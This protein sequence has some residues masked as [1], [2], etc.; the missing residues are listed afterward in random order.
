MKAFVL[1]AVFEGGPPRWLPS[2]QRSQRASAPAQGSDRAVF[3]APSGLLSR[4]GTSGQ[5][6]PPAVL[7][8]MERFFGA[9]FS[10]VRIHVGR[11]APS[12]G[13]LAFTAGTD[14]FFAPGRY[15][16]HAPTG[17][18]LLGHELTHVLQQRAGRVASPPGVGAAVV[19]DEALE[20]E[21]DRMGALAAAVQPRLVERAAAPGPGAAPAGGARRG[22][23][24]IVGAY[25]HQASGAPL[26]EQLSGH[27]FV[28]IEG[29][30]GRKAFGFSPANYSQYN[31][32]RDLARLSA[33]VRG[34]VHDDA[35]AF[36]KRGVRTKTFSIDERRANAAISKVAEYQSGRY[37]Y[38]LRDR[39]CST[40]AL[41]VARAAR[42]PVAG[43]P[44]ERRPV[45][46]LR[47]L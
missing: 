5:P 34:V 31:P 15:Q 18:A 17:Q 9:D 39:Q 32:R 14:I 16:P 37:A 38:S 2:I 10:A 33:G 1:Q 4:A 7:R 41:D 23:R 28:A 21:A 20:A 35:A 29:P 45:D 19:H 12:I 22:Y 43:G 11:E 46:V 30:H 47:K 3:R 40:F 24:L 42:I 8:K 13:A 27:S 6:L 26:P 44:P 36:D 25:P